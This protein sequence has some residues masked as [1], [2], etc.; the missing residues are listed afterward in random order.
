MKKTTKLLSRTYKNLSELSETRCVPKRPEF[1]NG[2]FCHIDF[3][4]QNKDRLQNFY[5]DVFNWKFFEYPNVPGYFLFQSPCGTQ[6]GFIQKDSNSENS[7][8]VPFYYTDDLD[9]TH[10]LILEHEG[11]FI[12]EIAPGMKKYQD[13]EGNCFGIFKYVEQNKK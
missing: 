12:V 5:H 9:K 6:G 2:S 8:T 4:Y 1:K 7:S 11:K 13:S 10:E 3:I